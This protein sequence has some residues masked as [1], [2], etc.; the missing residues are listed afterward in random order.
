[1]VSADLTDIVSGSHLALAAKLS[2]PVIVHALQ[3]VEDVILSIKRNAPTRGVVH[4][5]NGSQQQASQLIDL[6]Y[7]LSFGGAATYPRAKKIRRLIQS[8]P[9]ESI[10]IETDAPDQPG[11]K[12]QGQRNEPAF[13]TEVMQTVAE[14]RGERPESTAFQCNLNAENLFIF[15]GKN[16]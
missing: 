8:L 16:A 5:F 14:L 7:L 3:A 4:S 1:L 2:L 11:Y 13:L 6:G 10:L 15:D 9:A 12:Y